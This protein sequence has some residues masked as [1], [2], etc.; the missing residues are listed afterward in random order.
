MKVLDLFSGLDGWG[1]AFR[2]RGHDVTSIDLDRRFGSSLVLDIMAV[3]AL[4]GWDVVLASPPCE[5]FSVASI[6]THWTG[7][8]RA[9]EPNTLAA[10]EAIDLA[11]HTFQLIDAAVSD[12]RGPQFYVIENPRGVLR[13]IIEQRETRLYKMGRKPVTTWFCQWGENRAKPT[14]L[15]T[16]LAGD[17]PTCKNGNPDHEEARRGAKTGTQGIKGAAARGLIPYQ[18]SLAVCLACETDGQIRRMAKAA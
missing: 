10:K 18:L 14:D 4:N 15:W 6:G 5:C 17:W 3:K 12:K 13:K 16:N 1:A 11:W 9:Y 7:G 2:D 8:R